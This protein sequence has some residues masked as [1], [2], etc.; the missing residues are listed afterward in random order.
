MELIH[1]QAINDG[2]Y[3][4]YQSLLSWVHDVRDITN[5]HVGMDGANH[6]GVVV[7]ECS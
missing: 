5:H 2:D 1:K 6:E 7:V 3:K 4:Q